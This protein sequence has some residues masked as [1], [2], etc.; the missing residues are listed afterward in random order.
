MP[1]ETGIIRLN[2]WTIPTPVQFL[3]TLTLSGH[4]SGMVISIT[5]CTMRM[6]QK[7]C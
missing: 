7:C 2:D 4:W 1:E 5:H 6:L 3:S